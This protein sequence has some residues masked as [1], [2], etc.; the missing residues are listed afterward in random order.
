MPKL[1]WIFNRFMAPAGEDFS[2]GG[3]AIDRGD[4]FLPSGDDADGGT[5]ADDKGD[6]GDKAP[7]LKDL[8][9][10]D[11]DDDED[12]EEADK[13]KSK[14]EGESK[15]GEEGDDDEEGKDKDKS[16]GKREPR[17]P[18]SRHKASL[19]KMRAERDEMAQKLAKFQ[20]GQQVAAVNADITATENKI[21]ELEK[22]YHTALG[23]GDID[24]AAKLMRELRTLDA[25]VSEAKSDMKAA[26]AESRAVERVRYSVALERI[27]ESFPQLNQDHDSYDSELAQDV[28]DLKATYE[29]R[30]LTPTAALQKAVKRLVP[31]ETTKQES[32]TTVAP[33]VDAKDVAAE[34][35]KEAAKKTAAAVSKQPPSTTKAG[36]NSDALGG[37]LNGKDV[38]RMSQ[39]E[40]SKLPDEVLKNLRGDDI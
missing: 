2:T 10:G 31:T 36:L 27:E 37:G 28:V 29:A 9:G 5:A 14:A 33:R 21:L 35:K 30:G 1:H 11:D 16:K 20:Q 4:D 17:I 25:Q 8:D 13:A 39:D 6:K 15:D 19:D 24:E 23:D 38:M 3:G 12:D 34:R 32:A 7:S 22:K 40:F 26:A 18:L